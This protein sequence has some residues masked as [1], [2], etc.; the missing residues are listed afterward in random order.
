MNRLLKPQIFNADP[1]DPFA[2]KHYKHWIKTFTSF[3]NTVEQSLRLPAAEQNA[4]A[5]Y[6]VVDKLALLHCYLSPEIFDLVEE[7]ATYD[8]AKT[9]LDQTFLKQKNATYARHLLL[10][11]EQKPL[12]SPVSAACSSQS[13][14]RQNKKRCYFCAGNMHHGGR[15]ECPAKDC[16]CRGC[17]KKGHFY[18]ACRSSSK[19]LTAGIHDEKDDQISSGND[20]VA[21]SLSP[22]LFSLTGVP[23][24]LALSTIPVQIN[25]KT[26]YA[27]LDSGASHSHFSLNAVEWLKLKA[28]N[29]SITEVALA[30]QNATFK[31]LGK[32][33]AELTVFEQK[34]NLQ[35]GVT[36]NLRADLILDQDFIKRHRR[37]VFEVNEEGKDIIIKSSVC[38]VAVAKINPIRI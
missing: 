6:R 3:A 27:L 35:L 34:Y 2:Y 8:E 9:M 22:C 32:T 19:S 14:T 30:K 21:A 12:Q 38:T 16:Y 24:C 7:S 29:G 1:G 23:N 15:K 5:P 10:T 20:T 31:S 26:I 18:K 25:K 28:P 13:K 37:V 11:R 36:Q 17:G 4:D 33:S